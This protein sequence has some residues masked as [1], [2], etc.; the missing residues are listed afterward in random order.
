MDGAVTK[1]ATGASGVMCEAGVT[2]DAGIVGAKV[3]INIAFPSGL[4][5]A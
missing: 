4:M 1:G 5:G 2:G 3:V